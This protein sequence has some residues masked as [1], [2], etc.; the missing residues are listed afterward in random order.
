MAQ[1]ADDALEARGGPPSETTL[2]QERLTNHNLSSKAGM[3]AALILAGSSGNGGTQC[4]RRRCRNK[5]GKSRHWG[6][7]DIKPATENE[8]MAN[9]HSEGS[10]HKWSHISIQT[11]AWPHKQ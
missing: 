1:A 6:A 2:D 5:A 4:L 11:E 3:A 10:K 7:Q 8:V 9:L